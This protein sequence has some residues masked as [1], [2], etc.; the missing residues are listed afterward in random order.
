MIEMPRHWFRT[1]FC[2]ANL[3]IAIAAQGQGLAQPPLREPTG[4]ESR[5]LGE[6]DL[7]YAGAFRLP[8][9]KHGISSFDYGG[10]A[11]AYHLAADRFIWSDI[12]GNRPLAR[13]AFPN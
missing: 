1:A 10:T 6:N 7:K 13:L 2:C 9:G 3:L 4:S 8:G 5:L 12:T 11:M